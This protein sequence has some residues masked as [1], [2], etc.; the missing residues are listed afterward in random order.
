MKK[1]CYLLPVLF[2]VSCGEHQFTQSLSKG[3]IVSVFVLV[4]VLSGCGTMRQ[5]QVVE[6]VQKDTLY[7]NHIQYDSIF[8]ENQTFRDYRPSLQV[9]DGGRPDTVY[10]EKSHIEYKYK[11]L[12]DT[13]YRTQIDTIPV[14]S[15]V[16]VVKTERYIPKVYKASFCICVI[17]I[18][19]AICAFIMKFK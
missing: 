2:L 17:I 15:E 19:C 14:I 7:L 5:V 11:L 10:L 6:R 1:E 4:F 8:V 3:T 12:R 18:I 9:G 13:V 16:E